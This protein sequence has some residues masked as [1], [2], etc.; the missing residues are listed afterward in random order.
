[1]LV[2]PVRVIVM[3]FVSAVE[4]S[5][6]VKVRT[7]VFRSFLLLDSKIDLFTLLFPF[8]AIRM[9]WHIGNPHCSSIPSSLDVMLLE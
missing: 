4:C 2:P 9:A 6:I 3:E 7:R 5:A 8:L 1:M